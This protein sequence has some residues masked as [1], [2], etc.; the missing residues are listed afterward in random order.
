[1]SRNAFTQLAELAKAMEHS[2]VPFAAIDPEGRIAGGN[3]AF[4]APAGLN[5][6]EDINQK[7]WSKLTPALQRSAEKML[8][9]QSA[10]TSNPVSYEKNIILPNGDTVPVSVVAHPLA[11]GGHW[12]VLRRQKP[13]SQFID[14]GSIHFEALTR[15]FDDMIYICGPD[16][17]IEY[18]NPKLIRKLGRDAT[19][20]K[21][22]EALDQ[23]GHPCRWCVNDETPVDETVRWE[24]QNRLDGQRKPEFRWPIRA[25]VSTPTNWP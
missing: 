20:E 17:R 8:L 12:F 10:T 5:H 2:P 24:F 4:R 19:G 9:D 13:R 3:G 6:D 25:R 14:D 15:T 22:H 1:M 21:C 11:E 7:S 16:H 18:M 23:L